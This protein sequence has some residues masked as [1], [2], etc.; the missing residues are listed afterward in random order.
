MFADDCVIYKTVT[1]TFNQQS[2]QNNLNLVENWCNDWLMTLNINKCKYI[3]FHRHSNPLLFPYTISNVPIDP[4]QSYKYLGVHLSH[5]LTW[6]SHIANIISSANKTLGFLKRHLH[7][8][9]CM[10]SYSHTN[11]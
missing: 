11:H 7:S 3:S 1:D 6:N 2:L 10:L 4:V 5:D 8:A 9:P